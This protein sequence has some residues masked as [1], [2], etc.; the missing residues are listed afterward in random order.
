MGTTDKD[1]KARLKKQQHIIDQQ[2]LTIEGYSKQIT[3]LKAENHRLTQ[4]LQE[5]HHLL[6]ILR[7][8]NR[9]R[10]DETECNALNL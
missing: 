5:A 9:A 3:E 2:R 1:R 7:Q 6:D 10:L 8:S 4:Q